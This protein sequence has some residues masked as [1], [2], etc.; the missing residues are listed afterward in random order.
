M[1]FENT[2]KNYFKSIEQH[3]VLEPFPKGNSVANMATEI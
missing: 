1:I 2:F 3:A